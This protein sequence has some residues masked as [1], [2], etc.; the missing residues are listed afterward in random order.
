MNKN[1][2]NLRIFIVPVVLLF[3]SCASTVNISYDLS[4]AELIQR[5]QE[6]SDRNRYKTALDYY[7]ALLDR[8]RSSIDLVITAEYEIAFIHYKQK[9]YQQSRAELNSLLEYYNTP[10]EELLPPQFKRLAIIVL[11]RITEKEAPRKLFGRK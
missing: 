8:N 9:K 10:D 7:E 5:A 2:F 6:A 1:P 3:F 11:D 4:P